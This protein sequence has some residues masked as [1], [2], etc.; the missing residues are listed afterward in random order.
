MEKYQLCEFKLSG[1]AQYVEL[2]KMK[3]IIQRVK[4]IFTF[5]F[6]FSSF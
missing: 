1:G 5:N 4:Q 2:Q 3:K 6:Q